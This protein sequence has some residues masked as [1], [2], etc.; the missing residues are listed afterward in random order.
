MSN[1]DACKE[2]ISPQIPALHLLLAL[3]YRYLTPAE[4]LSLRGGTERQ[5]VLTAVLEDRLRAMNRICFKGQVEPFS[6]SNLKEALRRLT[7]EAA[8]EGL[9]TG[10]DRLSE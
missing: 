9:L 10:N 8:P 3:G 6:D 2:E 5:V 7:T 4:A 1:A